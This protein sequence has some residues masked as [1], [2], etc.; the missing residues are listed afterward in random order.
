MTWLAEENLRRPVAERL[1]YGVLLIKAV[2]LAL[3]EVPELNAVW[4]GAE[5]VRSESVHVGVA[6]ALR[7]G[8]VVAPALHDAD[9]RSLGELMRSFRD[10]V[11]RARA[12]E[13]AAPSCPTPPSQS[14]ASASRASRPCS[15]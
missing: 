2:A 7:G 13:F 8:G 3:R 10:L 4:R 14:R 9:R 11:R 5:A 15:A 1:L 6:I 12:G